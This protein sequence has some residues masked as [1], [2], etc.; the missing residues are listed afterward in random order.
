M[1]KLVEI[2]T[3]GLI[4]LGFADSSVLSVGAW[5]T[6]IVFV[7]L[8]AL[9]KYFLDLFANAIP[10]G[11]HF[12]RGFFSLVYDFFGFVGGFL[13]IGQLLGLPLKGDVGIIPNLLHLVSGLKD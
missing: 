6:V 4:L 11:S 10:E 9:D 13:Y 5:L 12:L 1:P 8:L 7:I 3:S 2:I